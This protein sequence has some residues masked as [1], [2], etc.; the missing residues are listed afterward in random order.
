MG[1]GG[2]WLWIEFGIF[3]KFTSANDNVT[4]ELKIDIK[5]LNIN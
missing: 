1:Y 4:D 5:I 2:P 3:F